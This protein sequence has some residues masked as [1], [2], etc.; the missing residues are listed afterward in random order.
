[1]KKFNSFYSLSFFCSRFRETARRLP[2][3]IPC[4]P[5]LAIQAGARRRMKIW[6][7]G[8]IKE[9]AEN[10]REI[11]G[12]PGIAYA[13][14]SKDSILEIQVSGY[15]VFKKKN[16]IEKKDRFNIGTNTAAFTAYIAARLV[17]AGKIKWNTTAA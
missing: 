9:E 8:R 1:M 6:L 14:F 13:V 17:Q 2:R 10:I 11:R 12:V 7:S 3:W 16:L 4:N 5:L 15:R